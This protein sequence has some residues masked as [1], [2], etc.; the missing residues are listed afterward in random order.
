MGVYRPPSMS[1]SVFNEL[2]S[3]MFGKILFENK[4]VYIF[5]DFNVNTM[6]DAIG[7]FNTREFKGIF[8]S[9]YCLPLITKPTKVTNSCASLIVNIY[10]NVPINTSKCNSGILKVSISDHYAIFAIDNFTPT[11]VNVSNA[12]KRSFCNKN[13]ENFKRCLINQSW[14]F[15]YESVD[16]QAAFSRFQRVIDVHFNSNFKLHTFTRT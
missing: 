8:S 3:D 10:S 7:N 4:Y 15:V 12:T 14:D 1:L 16:L 2:L 6:S 11:K 9:N 5:G 13:I